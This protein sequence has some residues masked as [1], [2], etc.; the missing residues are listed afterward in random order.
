MTRILSNFGTNFGFIDADRE[1]EFRDT[2]RVP[3]MGGALASFSTQSTG[4]SSFFVGGA[5]SI[6]LRF[7][8]TTGAVASQANITVLAVPDAPFNLFSGGVKHSLISPGGTVN[9]TAANIATALA[10]S[11]ATSGVTG[12]A[13]N[14]E[15]TL[16]T[17]AL[18]SETTRNQITIPKN[19]NADGTRRF[20]YTNFFFDGA[21]IESSNSTTFNVYGKSS[22]REVIGN[23]TSLFDTSSSSGRTGKNVIYAFDSSIISPFESMSASWSGLAAGDAISIYLKRE[24]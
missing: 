7:H 3:R 10:A 15:V 11:Q 17:T 13:L 6:S 9:E 5:K 16:T 2:F 14:E 8:V 22:S 23:G 18:G 21:S 19:K 12:V 20:A 24:F 1:L 4:V